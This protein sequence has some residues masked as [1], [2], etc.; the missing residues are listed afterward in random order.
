MSPEL[1]T[2]IV[3]N[4]HDCLQRECS[5]LIFRLIDGIEYFC[6]E[7]QIFTHEINHKRY[8]DIQAGILLNGKRLKGGFGSIPVANPQNKVTTCKL[9][10]EVTIIYSDTEMEVIECIV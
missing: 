1:H 3:I 10:E 9:R 5:Y 4:P 6:C 2:E 7:R 8:L